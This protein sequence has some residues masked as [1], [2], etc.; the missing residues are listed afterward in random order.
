MCSCSVSAEEEEHQRAF[1]LLVTVIQP[2]N[3]TEAPHSNQRFQCSAIQDFI[4]N[5]WHIIAVV[6][7]NLK[8]HA[9][10][11]LQYMTPV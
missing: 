5:L 8:Q 10:Q 1:S 4:V 9:N 3:M 2:K 11:I 7:V 6:V